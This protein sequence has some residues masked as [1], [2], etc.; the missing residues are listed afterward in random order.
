MSSFLV[1]RSILLLTW[2]KE[3]IDERTTKNTIFILGLIE[4]PECVSD[5]FKGSDPFFVKI[6]KSLRKLDPVLSTGG[7]RMA[8]LVERYDRIYP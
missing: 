6:E 7:Y 5:N 1:H 3:N 4:N 2:N 8:Q